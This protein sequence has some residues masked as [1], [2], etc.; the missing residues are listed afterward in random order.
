MSRGTGTIYS[1][2]RAHK[3]VPQVEGNETDSGWNRGGRTNN[4]LSAHICGGSS[5]SKEKVE[6]AA[7]P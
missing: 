7:V 5:G 4:R 3:P 1:Q 2:L 6:D